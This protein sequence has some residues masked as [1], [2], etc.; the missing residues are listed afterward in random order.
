MSSSC[1]YSSIS[2]LVVP[3]RGC[4][5]LGSGAGAGG[6]GESPQYFEWGGGL[7]YHLG[8]PENHIGLSL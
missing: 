2:G 3:H 4:I 7:E 1:D 8:T 6:G 5:G